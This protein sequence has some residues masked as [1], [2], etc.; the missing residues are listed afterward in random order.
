[1]FTLPNNA[2][3]AVVS[4]CCILLFSGSIGVL[5]FGS[6]GPS[7]RSGSLSAKRHVPGIASYTLRG[8]DA[9]TPKRALHG[10]GHRASFVRLFKLTAMRYRCP[11]SWSCRS[12]GVV[13]FW[14]VL[15]YTHA[16]QP[17]P[18]GVDAS[19]QPP[20]KHW[21]ELQYEDWAYRKDRA[22]DD[23]LGIDL[24]NRLI[25]VYMMKG[26]NEEAV[27][28]A[29]RAD[30]LCKS[31]VLAARDTTRAK[32]LKEAWMNTKD[33]L[34]S[35]LIRQEDFV[36][37]ADVS[38]ELLALA[39][40]LHSAQFASSA[41]ERLG[42]A[43]KLT[44]DPTSAMQWSDEQ[45]RQLDPNDRVDLA[46]WHFLRMPRIVLWSTSAKS[47]GSRTPKWT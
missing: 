26:R 28:V 39:Q 11:R 36:R 27:H 47:F 1:M 35:R 37:A 30:S 15:V 44:S 12:C 8:V 29:E 16:Q 20:V 43:Y 22:P 42:R 19:Q 6:S 7:G 41:Y 46:S 3:A 45:R 40:E 31:A 21:V 33:M 32:R 13:F 34:A 17:A 10:P 24:L 14:F 2:K 25:V 9:T 23:T 4:T 18:T 5:R 38:K